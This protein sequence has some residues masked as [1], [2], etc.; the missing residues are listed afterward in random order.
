MKP[1]ISFFKKTWLVLG[2]IIAIIVIAGCHFTQES[3]PVDAQSGCS[4]GPNGLTASEFNTW[5][6]SGGV[7]LNGA[8][9]P[10]N[11]VSFPSVPNCSFYKWSEQMF[12]WLTSPAT[13][14]YGNS[15]LV[16]TSP[17]FFDVS[18]P[19]ADG[20]RV[21]E[22]HTGG[23]SMMKLRTPQHGLLDLPVLREKGT[24]KLLEIFPSPKSA[25]GNSIVLNNKGERVEVADFRVDDQK[26]VILLDILGKEIVSPHPILAQDSAQL[27][28]NPANNLEM[29]M[30]RF[31]DQAKNSLVADIVVK[32]K[33]FFLDGSGSFHEVEQGQSNGEVLVA[34]N[35]SLVYYTLSVNNVFML[36]RTMQGSSP[37][38][39][40]QFPTSQAQL[41]A[42]SS[43]ASAH[44]RSPIIDSFA[45][46]I[47]VKSSWVEA[48]GLKDSTSFIIMPATIPTYDKTNPAHWVPNGT[49][50]VNLALVGIHVVGS[51][52]Q[53]PEMLWATFEHVSNAP[54]AD[55][56]YNSTSGLK[57]ITQ[58]TSGVWNFC[59]VTPTAPF[60]TAI[61]EMSGSDIVS[62]GG[63]NI[64]PSN[65]RREMPFGMPGNNASSNAEVIVMN[66][67]VRSLLDPN[68]V[69]K[70][71]IQTGTTWF[72]PGTTSQVGTNNLANTTM[73]TFHQPSNCFSCHSSA[74][75]GVSHIFF[76]TKPLF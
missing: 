58:P 75:V 71:Y 50:T 11:S 22:P 24:N 55:Y 32:N 15:G 53:H 3:L 30:R 56:S 66:N 9:N 42:V 68:D 64:G 31:P 39:S 72:I 70:N 52:A 27:K 28:I 65:V 62:I 2:I 20:N 4:V 25:S 18:L 19:G 17:A 37:S 46:S 59:S 10:A 57:T 16:L 1:S 61:N 43:F 33:H 76:D 35:G 14:A 6:K 7:S 45:L 12:L 63:G 23:L 73:E 34:Q 8:V 44:N 54:A 67:V 38:V 13:G 5:F 49:K 51:T 60:N 36:F 29:K 21:F 40:L 74:T 26:R 41:N 47:E 69:R 48:A